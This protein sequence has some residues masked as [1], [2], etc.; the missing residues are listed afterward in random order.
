MV[1]T[2]SSSA[3]SAS[4]DVSSRLVKPPLRASGY[5]LNQ[6]GAEKSDRW[7]RWAVTEPLLLVALLPLAAAVTP[8]GVARGRR[9]CTPGCGMSGATAAVAE[10]DRNDVRS[11]GGRD[12]MLLA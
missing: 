12:R 10:G 3:I 9:R 5:G 1:V 6:I 2:I 4:G 7:R 11:H 8:T